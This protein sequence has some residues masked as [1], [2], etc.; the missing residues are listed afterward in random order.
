MAHEARTRQLPP[1][2]NGTAAVASPSAMDR[3]DSALEGLWH[4]LSSMRVALVLMLLLAVAGVVGSLVIQMPPGIAASAEAQATWVN[5]VRPRYGFLTDPMNALGVFDIFNS[6][7]FRALGAALTISLIACS[8]HR[9]PGMWRTST[10]PRVDVGPSFFEHAPQ[11]EA[12]V[13]RMTPAE[14]RAA[15]QGVLR[16]HRYRV[17]VTEDDAVHIYADR[18]RWAPFAGLIGHLSLVVILAGAIIGATFGFRD[19]GF[20][21]PE[22]ENLAVAAEAGLTIELIDFTDTYYVTTGAP[23]DFASQVILRKDGEEIT[24]H[25]I[26]VNDPLRY[27][28]TS[29]Y[30]SF[31]GVAAVMKV[32]DATGAEIAAESVP[33]AWEVEGGRKGG[34]FTIPGTRYVGEVVGTAGNAD[35]TILPGQMQVSLFEAATGVWIASQVVDQGKPTSIGD[36]TVTFER[37]SQFTGLS[38]ARDPGVVIVWIGSILLFVGFVIR[39]MVPHKRLWARITPGPRGGSVVGVASLGTKDV[40][41]NSE[42]DTMVSDIRAAVQPPAKS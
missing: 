14:T 30:Q 42:F 2:P 28:A 19:P 20:T 7:I 9:F 17:L 1:A 13:V 25:T 31:F 3:V 10:K 15:V 23:S 24:R 6:V 34:T 29:F 37:E 40:V 22:G 36:L 18:F 12:V 39:F 4:L 5:E 27:G 21:L 33:L 16:R 11:H 35:P 38:I 41:A 26:R 8:V 32:L